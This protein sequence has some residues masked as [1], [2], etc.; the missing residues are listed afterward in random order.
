MSFLD[1]VRA[2]A[3]NNTGVIANKANPNPFTTP[4][5]TKPS[6][7]FAAAK[8]ASPV[9]P[10]M[11]N[12]PMGAP[13]GMQNPSLASAPNMNKP[14][15]P[16]APVMARP[17]PTVPVVPQQAKPEIIEQ[18]V[19][20]PI[21][22]V[23]QEEVVQE[24]IQVEETVQEVAQK[25]EDVA[26]PVEQEEKPKRARRGTGKKKE[27][28]S[29]QKDQDDDSEENASTP[30]EITRT[31]I[32]YADAVKAISSNFFDSE[33]ENYRNEMLE[34]CDSITFTTDM[35]EGAIKKAL[36]QLDTLRN[37]V[38]VQYN[39]TKIIYESLSSKDTEG[40]IER[41]KYTSN[42]G[43]NDSSR[44]RAAVLAVMNHRTADGD[45]VNLYE[46]YDETKARFTFLKSL[47]DTIKYKSDLLIT[48]TGA[49]KSEKSNY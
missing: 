4:T 25:V 13:L 10:V 17:T 32:S 7:P 24:V 16:S 42:D 21:E 30:I 12:K 31:S 45:I 8:A 40:K 20:E 11:A 1:N 38:W 14:S 26:S 19:A 9:A 46:V 33:W 18:P 34:E 28:A 41:I 36:A 27:D 23:V 2:N 29:K 44:K 15:I 47:M 6:N 22:E 37:K 3:V 49:V 39:D 43:A 48:A 5:A 35:Q